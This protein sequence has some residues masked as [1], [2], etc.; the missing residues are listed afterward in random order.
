M[1]TQ[2]TILILTTLVVA[3]ATADDHF[4]VRAN[5]PAAA[6]KLARVPVTADIHIADMCVALEVDELVLDKSLFSSGI[7]DH[8]A[9]YSMDKISDILEKLI[10]IKRSLLG[11]VNPKIAAQVIPA[12]LK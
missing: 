8:Y 1:R 6:S 7:L 12:L 9:S 4:I 5:I 10:V 11:N 3:G 2:L